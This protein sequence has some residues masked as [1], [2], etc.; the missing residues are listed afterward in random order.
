MAR[1]ACRVRPMAHGVHPFLAL[2]KQGY[3]AAGCQC[4]GRPD[5][6]RARPDRFDDRTRTPTCG[7]GFKKKRAA[8]ARSF[9]GWT[10]HQAASGD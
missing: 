5:G 6:N 2:A 1:F 9:P 3:M 7:R 8:S 10:E 4:T